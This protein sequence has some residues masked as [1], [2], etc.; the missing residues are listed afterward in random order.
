M[1]KRHAR[2]RYAFPC[3]SQVFNFVRLGD[4]RSKYSRDIW[5]DIRIGFLTETG[6][7]EKSFALFRRHVWLERRNFGRLGSLP[8]LFSV[9][10]CGRIFYCFSNRYQPSLIL[11]QF[12]FVGVQS[13]GCSETSRSPHYKRSKHCFD[14]PIDENC[15][16]W[17]V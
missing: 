17:F 10:L 5:R 2:L 6:F 13:H 3:F 4:F 11:W 9:G 8:V 15:F 14:V 1:L 12:S 7:A 16:V